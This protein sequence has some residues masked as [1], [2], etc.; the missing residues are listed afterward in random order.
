MEAKHV[1]RFTRGGDP[2]R[3]LGIGQRRRGQKISNVVM[4]TEETRTYEEVIDDLI[5]QI[6]EVAMSLDM[7]FTEQKY[8]PGLTVPHM[9]IEDYIKFMHLDTYKDY[10]HAHN[11]IKKAVNTLEL[12]SE[13]LDAIPINDAKSQR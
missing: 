12:L 6:E 2:Y 8:N 13:L 3:K 10:E 4:P 7:E 11:Q 9:D 5:I 1:N